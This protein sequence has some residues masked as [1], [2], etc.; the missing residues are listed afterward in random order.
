MI[1]FKEYCA[2]KQLDNCLGLGELAE[3]GAQNCKTTNSI[4]HI[5]KAQLFYILENKRLQELGAVI[6]FANCIL[7][8]LF[9]VF[10]E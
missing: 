8:E 10:S 5:K 4:P 7:N 6:L 1:E 3:F 9:Q 2:V